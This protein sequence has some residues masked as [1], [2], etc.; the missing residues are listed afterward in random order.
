[1]LFRSNINKNNRAILS[2]MGHPHSQADWEWEGKRITVA[3]DIVPLMS[4][5][6]IPEAEQH[7]IPLN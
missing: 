4:L 2:E 6:A 5:P 7:W 1:M 3:Y